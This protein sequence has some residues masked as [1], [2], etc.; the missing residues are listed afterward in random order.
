M[1]FSRLEEILNKFPSEKI[2]V[3]GDFF[4]DKWLT[5]DRDLDEISIETGLTAYQVVSKRIF[6][7]AAGTV[8]ANLA[9][10]EIGEL[11]AI[12]FVGDDGE[13]FELVKDLNSKNVNTDYLMK[14]TKVMT[15]TY[16]KPMFRQD[17]KETETNRL[18]FKNTSKTPAELEDFVIESLWK[19][20]ENVKAIIAL[21]QLVDEGYGVLTPR[22]RQALTEISLKYSDLIIYAD[23]RA[24]INKFENMI[25][26]CNDLEVMKICG[27]T[28][29]EK[30]DME[31]VKQNTVKLS[32]KTSKKVFV[33][34]GEKGVLAMTNDGNVKLVE[35]IPQTGEIDIV[36]AGDACTAGIVSTLCAGATAEEAAFV[37]NLASSITIQVIGTTGTASRKQILQ[38]Y[39]DYYNKGAT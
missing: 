1:N 37:G 24:F 20:A 16:T 27:D 6:A 12:G 29:G 10:L 32:E 31:T 36:G 19:V 2:A 26:K 23:S 4:L 17:G 7:G 38:R 5:V 21:D 13:G 30:Q 28:S 35:T 34:C 14:S 11:Y 15:P 9:T 3:V 8:L 25:I 33:T 18:D 22:V 39:E